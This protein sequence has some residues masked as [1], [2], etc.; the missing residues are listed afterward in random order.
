MSTRLPLGF[1]FAG[2][3]C[4]IK[5]KPQNPDIALIVS[6]RPATAAGVYTQNRIY[7][8]PVQVD[9]ERTPNELTQAVVVNSG[10]AN[11]CTGERG[12][13]DAR[14][15]CAIVAEACGLKQNSVLVMSTGIIGEHLPMKKINSGIRAAAAQLAADEASVVAAARGIMTTDKVHKLASRELAMAKA[16]I[17]LLGMAKGSGMIGPKMATMLGVIVTDAALDPATAQSMLCEIVDQTFN[18]ISVEGHTSTNDTV[19]LLANGAAIAEPLSGQEL[20]A[21]RTALLELSTELARSIPADGE[22]A[23]HLITVTVRG[24]EDPS[25]ARHI[26]RAIANSPLVKTA[27][28]GA[29]PNWGR[30]VSAAGYAGVEFDPGRV[31]LEINGCLLFDQGEPVK[32]DAEQVSNSI[33]GNVDTSVVLTVGTGQASIRFWTSDLTAEYVRIN[34]DYHT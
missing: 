20:N 24:C 2:V 6:D 21:F 12:L 18:C 28:A 16:E 25:D 8:A 30:I 22:G 9:R 29:D 27:V 4:G 11:A 5:R 33:R 13:R 17:G 14:Q 3:H 32:Y 7:A 1:R 34:A 23:T 31:A 26:A 15:M 19:L 10:N